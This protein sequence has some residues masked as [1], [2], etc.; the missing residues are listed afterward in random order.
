MI[1]KLKKN[2]FYCDKDIS[3]KV[4]IYIKKELDSAYNKIFLKTKKESYGDEA[5]DFH[6]KEIILIKQ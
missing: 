1:L 3:F 2:K 6:D 5:T 4:S